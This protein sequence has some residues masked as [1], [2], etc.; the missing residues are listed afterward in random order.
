MIDKTNDLEYESKPLEDP[1]STDGKDFVDYLLCA[2]TLKSGGSADSGISLTCANVID[3]PSNTYSVTSD[4]QNEPILKS[5]RVIRKIMKSPLSLRSIRM[6]KKQQAHESRVD[7]ETTSAEN[8]DENECRDE[9]VEAT[10]SSLNKLNESFDMPVE[11][12]TMDQRVQCTPEKPKGR[13]KLVGKSN[14]KSTGKMKNIFQNKEKKKSVDMDIGIKLALPDK[15]G[16]MRG[17]EAPNS[18]PTDE[19]LHRHYTANMFSTTPQKKKIFKTIASMS[20][21]KK[22]A[23]RKSKSI[24][25]SYSIG[26]K[27]SSSI[28]NTS[29]SMGRSSS[30]ICQPNEIVLRTSEL[31]PS[32]HQTTIPTANDVLIHARVCALFERYDRMLETRAI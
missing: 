9:N 14:K 20:L 28:C 5:N 19:G 2:P 16:V 24:N 18:V 6:R 3:Q 17:L 26:S 25:A 30:S 21:F 32:V 11:E 22:N 4:D 27:T 12:T 29:Y 31:D 15:I 7:D 8:R 13:S 23:G 10:T 1:S